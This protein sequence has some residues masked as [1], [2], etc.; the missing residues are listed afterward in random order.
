[1]GD[2]DIKDDVAHHIG[3]ERVKWR[4]ASMVLCDKNESLRPLRALQSGG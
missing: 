4:L 2:G 3:A 1:M